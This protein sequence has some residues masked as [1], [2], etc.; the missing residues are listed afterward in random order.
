MRQHELESGLG[1]QRH[2][3]KRQH[4]ADWQ[5]RLGLHHDVSPAHLLQCTILVLLSRENRSAAGWM[6]LVD[7]RCKCVVRYDSRHEISQK[8]VWVGRQ[9]TP[10]Q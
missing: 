2:R 7:F 1:I 5:P 8:I 4:G 9:R 3:G 10:F 6:Q